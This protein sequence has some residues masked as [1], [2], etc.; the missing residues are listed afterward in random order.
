MELQANGD[1]GADAPPVWHPAELRAWPQGQPKAQAAARVSS[2]PANPRDT[3]ATKAAA[4]WM[5]VRDRSFRSTQRYW[6]LAFDVFSCFRQ[7]PPQ[8]PI[9]TSIAIILGRC[10]AKSAPA[11]T[12]ALLPRQYLCQRSQAPSPGKEQT[13][14]GFWFCSCWQQW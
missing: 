10:T 11:V 12:P 5:A 13:L 14:V 8:F 2:P 7:H 9:I 4:G 1:A 6:A 3:K